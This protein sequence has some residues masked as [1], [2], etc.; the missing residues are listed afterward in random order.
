VARLIANIGDRDS[1]LAGG[2]AERAFKLPDP[3]YFTP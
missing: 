2:H 3:F 1:D